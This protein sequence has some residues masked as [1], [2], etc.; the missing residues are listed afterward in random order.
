MPAPTLFVIGDSISLHYGPYL[1]KRLA[2][3]WAYERKTGEEAGVA[4]VDEVAD[5]N[6]GDSSRVLAY[7]R[8]R[9]AT[10]R[11]RPDLLL[12]NC[13]LHDLKTDRETGDKQVPLGAYAGNLRS[14][15]G[16]LLDAGICTVWIRTTPVCEEWHAKNKP[17]DR[18]AADVHAYNQ[19]ADAIM[20]EAGIPLLDLHGFTASLEHPNELLPDGVHFTDAT[21]Q[22]QAAFIAGYVHRLHTAGEGDAGA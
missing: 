22:L 5:P 2:G 11:F 6:G 17:F 18:F 4:G 8:A 14:V 9:L 13:G 21:R 19:T 10:G 16:E 3:T 1:E 7:L 20:R 12:L 15:I